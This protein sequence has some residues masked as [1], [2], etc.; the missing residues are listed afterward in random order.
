MKLGLLLLLGSAAVACSS[1]D[2]TVSAAADSGSDQDST[3][4]D[5]AED[6]SATDTAID[7]AID[8]CAPEPG[9]AK[10]CVDVRLDHAEHPG[11]DAGS[12]AAAL[13]IDGKGVVYVSLFDKDPAVD[14]AAGGT[15][16]K[17]VA[18]LQYP[19]VDHVGAEATIDTDLT[20]SPITLSGRATPGTYWVITQFTD[21]KATR[22]TGEGGVLAGDFVIVPS[23]D[24]TT[25][26]ALYPKVTLTAG[27]TGR[28]EQRLF[29][30]RRID[31]TLGVA[32]ELASAAMANPNI[33]GD[34]P[35]LFA[36]YE[37]DISA[38]P[39]NIL[40]VGSWPCAKMNPAHTPPST[41]GAS[42]GTTVDGM[43]K[44]FAILFDY[45]VDIAGRANLLV[46]T[47]DGIAGRP[48]P[49][50]N[51]S[52]TS[53]VSSAKADFI[54]DYDAYDPSAPPP[55]PDTLVCP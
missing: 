43:H 46:Q 13:G 36:I 26:K 49:K 44:L 41:V 37:G 28:V 40:S 25:R 15:A 11:Y 52:T 17:P 54:V 50:V 19:P 53:W 16:P 20:V 51:I 3:A 5:A 32:A 7:T 21:S 9:V 38:K 42:F 1:G 55:M 31:V 8:P 30:Y 29:P 39:P 2:F 23:V 22:T 6:S 34:G 18:V 48:I 33:H 12:G 27:A 4:T 10:F 45:K 24:P 35:V 14:V 47:S